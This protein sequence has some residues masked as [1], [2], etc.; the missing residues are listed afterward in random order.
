MCLYLN[1][2]TV[3]L[4]RISWQNRHRSFQN[5]RLVPTQW[6]VLTNLDFTRVNQFRNRQFR[7][8]PRLYRPTSPAI[9]ALTG[10]T[11]NHTTVRDIRSGRPVK[12]Q[13]GENF[14]VYFPSFSRLPLYF[15]R[16]FPY[17]Q[18]V[19]ISAPGGIFRRVRR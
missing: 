13:G 16:Y 10:Q 7:F 6:R 5:R 1:I 2:H 3:D 14:L 18:T 11:G 15:F 12:T 19:G 9:E 8:S 4:P 17:N